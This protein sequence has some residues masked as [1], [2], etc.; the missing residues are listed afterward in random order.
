MNENWIDLPSEELAGRLIEQL[1]A[2]APECAAQLGSASS[3]YPEPL[4]LASDQQLSETAQDSIQ[5]SAQDRTLDSIQDEGAGEKQPGDGLTAEELA[6]EELAQAASD[7]RQRLAIL[8][9]ILFAAATPVDVAELAQVCSWPVSVVQNDL[10]IL[11]LL[12][13]QRGIRLQYI[14]GACRL[15]TAAEYSP[16]VERYLHV[17]SRVRLSRAQL[18]TLAVIAYN[19]PITKAV[20]DTYRGVRSERVLSQL[21]DLHLIKE[22]A[23]AEGPGRP[24]LYAT[25]AEFLRYFA[26]NSLEDLPKLFSDPKAAPAAGQ[27]HTG[28]MTQMVLDGEESEP[29]AAQAEKPEGRDLG[30]PSESLRKLLAR[31]QRRQKREGQ[32]REDSAD[33]NGSSVQENGC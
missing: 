18:E 2:I 32:A 11:K 31:M 3:A 24:I 7:P 1:T 16:W 22:A 27:P 26:L 13:A 33:T 17:H 6:A 30:A 14:A 19:Q 23:R 12:L 10:E 8:E 29:G 21:E 5:D 28:E 9:A 15:V 4:L 20:I 25:T